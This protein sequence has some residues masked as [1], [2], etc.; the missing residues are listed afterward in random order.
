IDADLLHSLLSPVSESVWVLPSS[1]DP[2]LAEAFDAAAANTVL[3]QLRAHFAF[4]VVDCAH[5]ISDRTL[6]AFDA[7]TRILLVTQLNVQALRS[8]QRT[9]ALCR[10]LGYPDDKIHV[11]VNRHASGDLVSVPDAA[12]VLDRNI[13]FRLPNDYK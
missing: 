10:R 2:E 8:T 5:H 12:Q 11:V 1:E 6:A 9:L 4:T 7:A 13:F 3:D